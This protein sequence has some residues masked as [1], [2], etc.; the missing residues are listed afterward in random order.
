MIIDCPRCGE[1]HVEAEVLF[2]ANG[3]DVDSEHTETWVVLKCQNI[4]CRG[5]VLHRSVV[6]TGEFIGLFP[7]G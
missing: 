2:S 4:G 1:K 7:G 3:H 6:D 5:L